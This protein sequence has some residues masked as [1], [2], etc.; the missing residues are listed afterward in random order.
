MYCKSSTQL[1]PTTL[2]L[3]ACMRGDLGEVSTL[4]SKYRKDIN[5]QTLIEMIPDRHLLVRMWYDISDDDENEDADRATPE[6]ED[7]SAA[8]ELVLRAFE[9]DMTLT[10]IYSVFKRLR[11]V[12]PTLIPVFLEL[13]ATRLV[14]NPHFK[15]FPLCPCGY[16]TDLIRMYTNSQ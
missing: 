16:E 6:N 5:V 15:D 4:I 1:S 13:F 2:L 3:A 14:T 12:K 8:I 7:E 9:V 11:L 10:A